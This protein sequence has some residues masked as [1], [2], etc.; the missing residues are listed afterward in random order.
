MRHVRLSLAEI[1]WVVNCYYGRKPLYVSLSW[2]SATVY[3]Y[4]GRRESRVWGFPGARP[5]CRGTLEARVYILGVRFG[6]IPTA[7][8]CP[9]LGVHFGRILTANNRPRVWAR[10]DEGVR[11]LITELKEFIVY[12]LCVCKMDQM[13]WSA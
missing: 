6:R 2:V 11:R 3:I 7:I 4:R 9:P 10:V 12:V 13:E 1:Q 5:A 8:N